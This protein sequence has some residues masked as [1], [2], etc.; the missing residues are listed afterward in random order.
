[1]IQYQILVRRMGVVGDEDEQTEVVC[2]ATVLGD[3]IAAVVLRGLAD[4]IAPPKPITRAGLASIFEGAV[5]GE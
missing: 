4:D 2:D 3:D 5:R 1:M